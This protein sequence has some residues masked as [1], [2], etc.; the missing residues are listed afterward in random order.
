MNIQD[1]LKVTKGKLINGKDTILLKKFS[2]DSRT[3]KKGDVFIAIKG[4]NFDGHKFV[5][6]AIQKGA[7][8]LVVSKPIKVKSDIPVIKVK[9]TTEAFGYIASLHRQ[10]FDI[11][12]IAITGSAG[13]TTTKEMIALVL[14]AKYKVLKNY[15]TFNNHY[16]VPQTLLKLNK[17]HQILVIELGTNQPG[18]IPW[19]A[20]I[21]QPT[22]C[23]FTNVG[24]S[25]LEKLKSRAG[26]FREKIQMLKFCKND[27]VV[28]YNADDK[29]FG[30]ISKMR[31]PQKKMS[32]GIAKKA[33]FRAK[34]IQV[35]GQKL[36]F[37][38]NGNKYTVKSILEHNICNA[39]AGICCGSLFRIGY[40]N[41]STNLYKYKAADGR[42][43]FKRVGPIRVLNDT[44]NANPLSF[45][46]AISAIDQ[47]KTN[48]RKF[49][50]CADMLELGQ[51]AKQLH[52]SVG[53]FI[54]RSS[55]TDLLS[56]GNKAKF[57]STEA[58]K[59]RSTLSVKHYQ[60]LAEINQVLKRRL[61]PRDVVLVKGSR[62]MHM[63]RVV[64]Y[65]EKNFK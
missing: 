65:L 17:S 22:V 38:V 42:A 30:K 14:S 3:L 35:D 63:E 31:I 1:I 43:E 29:Y 49:V 18:D 39:I 56:L 50:V 4:D 5:D 64:E 58:A 62:G 41:I 52:Q 21:V 47:Y 10:Q 8:A 45:K 55:V 19:L 7:K 48:G 12:V 36:G 15:K 9:D 2:I 13:K 57:V 54:A 46:S 59:K 20:K 27:G 44:Y 33:S 60:S 25:H 61:K 51:Q 28:V 16:G 24:D 32:Y 34:T 37:V 11:P 26:V 53:R 6:L 23:V 40:N